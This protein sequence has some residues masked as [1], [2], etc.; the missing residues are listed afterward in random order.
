M[1]QLEVMDWAASEKS[2][3]W[4]VRSEPCEATDCFWHPPQYH[5]YDGNLASYQRARL[6][7]DLSGIDKSTI[8]GFE[9]EE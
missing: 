4:L 6:L 1:T 7:P 8:Q 3:G 2:H 9:A 5:S